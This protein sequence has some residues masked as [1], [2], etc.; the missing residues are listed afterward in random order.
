MIR[1]QVFTA[2]G[3]VEE[4]YTY[5]YLGDR[6]S[7][8]NNG[9]TTFYTLDYSSGLSQN[10]VIKKGNEST[11]YVRGFDLISGTKGND[12]FFYLY[13]GGNSVRG[14]SDENGNLTDEYVF[15]AFGNKISHTGDS[16]NE[17]GFQGE[18]Q[19]ETGLYYLRARYMDPET[20]A[21]TSMDTFGGSLSD[22]MSMH[23][24]LFANSNPVMFCD[25]SGHTSLMEEMT[26]LDIIEI[27]AAGALT[28][29]AL[30]MLSAIDN[31][32]GYSFERGAGAFM[33]GLLLAAASIALVYMGAHVLLLIIG[34]ITSP[35]TII[36]GAYDVSEGRVWSGLYKIFLG[37]VG[38]IGTVQMA[39]AL[40]DYYNELAL[41]RERCLDRFD[42]DR[43]GGGNNSSGG[44]GGN[45]SGGGNGGNNSG[46]G[47]GGNNSG[48]GN[49]G[50]NSGGGNGGNNSG[51]GNGGNN[52]GGGNG[53]NSSGG[54]NG[55]N[56]SGGGPETPNL[57][58]PNDYLQ[59]ALNNQNLSSPPAEMKEVWTEGGYKYTVRIHEGDPRYTSA[60]TIYRVSRQAL[61]NGQEYL[62]SDG[63]WYHKSVL[64]EF[65]KDGSPNPFYNEHA[66]VVTHIPLT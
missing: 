38:L 4:T 2:I 41:E 8:T 65:Y 30:D 13:D 53:G 23:K 43:A 55:G 22:P 49:G 48:G 42:N 3:T 50:N 5:N 62:G 10:L 17:Y 21:F 18:Q 26:V 58:N 46:G 27:L 66:A 9:V 32:E 29:L 52:S 56:N 60:N 24:Y 20:G 1:A 44:N 64:T 14:I 31:G 25:P 57:D 51:G 36:S 40:D 59:K 12:T 63:I 34:A 11:F 33:K 19:D 37:I 35:L 15:D 54:G 61:G 45:N 28:S 39:K 47:N 6:T 7:K 16:E